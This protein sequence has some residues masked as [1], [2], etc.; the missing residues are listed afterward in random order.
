M[1]LK[2]GVIITEAQGGY[3][4]VDA[5]AGRGRFNGMIKMNKTAAFVANLLKDGAD[6]ESLVRAM[7]E[8]FD[9]S[10]KDARD[11]VN[12]VVANLREAGLIED[13]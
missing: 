1:K 8:K 13:E 12:V 3:V 6:E 2:N 10:E 9:V 4:A 7:L 5:N 11:S